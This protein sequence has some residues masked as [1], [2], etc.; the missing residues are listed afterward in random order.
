M[1]KRDISIQIRR[2]GRALFQS[3]RVTLADDLT[4]PEDVRKSMIVYNKLV[5][6]RRILTQKC[7]EVRLVR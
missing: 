3:W 6:W 1:A 7:Q 4:A 5:T 2:L